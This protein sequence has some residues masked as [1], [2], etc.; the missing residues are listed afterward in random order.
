MNRLKKSLLLSVIALASFEDTFAQNVTPIQ[1]GT[2]PKQ[3]ELTPEQKEKIIAKGNPK[4]DNNV[5]KGYN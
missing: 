3:F 5:V 4:M 2:P 1:N